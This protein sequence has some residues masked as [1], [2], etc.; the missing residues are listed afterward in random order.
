MEDA[1]S[2]LAAFLAPRGI[3]DLALDDAARA[4]FDADWVLGDPDTVGQTLADDLALGVDGY[5]L[6]LVANGH[7]PDRV[8]LLGQTASKVPGLLG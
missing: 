4:R 7:D 8:A 2:E 3:D 5:V 1:R 6:S